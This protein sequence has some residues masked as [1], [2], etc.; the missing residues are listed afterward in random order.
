MSSKEGE[1]EDKNAGRYCA[2]TQEQRQ[3]AKAN[4]LAQSTNVM[5]LMKVT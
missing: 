4:L 5:L 2:V 3:K 1:T